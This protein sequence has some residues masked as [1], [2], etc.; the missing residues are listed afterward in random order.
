MLLVLVVAGW[1]PLWG[2][3]RA[4]EGDLQGKISALS[5]TGTELRAHARALLDQISRQRYEE[6]ENARGEVR[7]KLEQWMSGDVD[8]KG[9][10]VQRM[11]A[12]AY[13][14]AEGYGLDTGRI[15]RIHGV[16]RRAILRAD[17]FSPG[18]TGI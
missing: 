12:E 13:R 11:L 16:A 15:K 8:L 3:A 9:Q 6:F 4:E 5:A 2:G 1:P 10:Q 7:G 14:I 18:E 17:F